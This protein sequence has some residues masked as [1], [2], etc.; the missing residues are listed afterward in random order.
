LAFST[1]GDFIAEHVTKPH[2]SLLL[3]DSALLVERTKGDAV[4]SSSLGQRKIGILSEIAHWQYL[5]DTAQAATLLGLSYVDYQNAPLRRSKSSSSKSLSATLV[6]AKTYDPLVRLSKD[7][8]FSETRGAYYAFIRRCLKSSRERGES[9]CV[10]VRILVAA[11]AVVGNQ[12][13][14]SL[15]D[16]LEFLSDTLSFNKRKG[17]FK[18]EDQV[19]V[20]GYA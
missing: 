16:Q 19:I 10:D 17:N 1:A 20:C 18:G 6:F 2:V 11:V 9:V 7:L 4:A 8:H 14:C 5:T 13:I 3:A 12:V 15:I